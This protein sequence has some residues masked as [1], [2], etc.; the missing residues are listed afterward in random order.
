MYHDHPQGT[1]EIAR[2]VD[3][4]LEKLPDAPGCW[5]WSGS[6]TPRGYGIVSYGGRQYYVHRVM[7]RA[8]NGPIP[9]GYDVC[10]RCDIP[11]C[12]RPDHLFVGTRA[13]NVRDS[14]AKGRSGRLVGE[15]SS[16]AKLTLSQVTEIRRRLSAGESGRSLAPHYGVA[17]ETINSIRRGK[18]WVSSPDAARIKARI[19]DTT[20][21]AAQ[22]EALRSA[23][24]GSV[25]LD[26]LLCW[27][28]EGRIR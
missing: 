19:L 14:V 13:D 23:L 8:L 27:L 11:S 26:T 15:S 9:P 5:L 3:S 21:S 25:S 1:S 22:M 16:M 17:A 18:S 24:A 7:Y 6:G 20:W 12:A 10:H 2:Y 28:S 4:R